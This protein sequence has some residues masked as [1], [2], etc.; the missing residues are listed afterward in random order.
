MV[1]VTLLSIGEFARA[2]RLSV[3]ALRH[4]DEVDVLK[5]AHVDPHTGFRHYA[6]SQLP[7]ALLITLLRQADIG[8]PAVRSAL[9]NQKDLGQLVELE[10]ERLR[11]QA[12]R[13]ERALALASSLVQNGPSPYSPTRV[14]IETERVERR[15]GQATA[16]TLDD[17]VPAVIRRLVR[18][19]VGAPVI[20]RF[21]IQ[22]DGTFDFDVNVPRPDGGCELVGGEFIR[23]VH[24]GPFALLPLAYHALFGELARLEAPAT[25]PV[26]ERYLSDPVRDDPA[27]L[28]TEVLLRI[29]Q[30]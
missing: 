22:L 23:V 4:Y 24:R 2:S 29:D 6:P 17:V 15:T 3:K 11:T 18:G 25:G 9:A 5:P 13:A 28:R 21:P 16:E 12:R 19:D 14:V 8:L 30:S 26:R 10:L 1:H 7:D 27:D 20:G